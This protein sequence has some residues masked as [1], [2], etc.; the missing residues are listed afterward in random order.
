MKVGVLIKI[1]KKRKS[2]FIREKVQ[3]QSNKYKKQLDEC[4]NSLT[5]EKYIIF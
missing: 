2:Y 1:I 4:K 5:T 3:Q